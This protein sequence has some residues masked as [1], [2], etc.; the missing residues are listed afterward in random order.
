MMRPL[1]RGEVGV[2]FFPT[3]HR[4]ILLEGDFILVDRPF[5]PGD[6]CKRSLD[7]V[8]SGVVTAMEVKAILEHAI[9][10]SPV[11]GWIA[12]EDVE[13]RQEAEIGDYVAYDDWIGQVHVHESKV[14]DL[15]AYS[16]PSR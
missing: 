3:G 13:K 7:D 10:G 15:A 12:M 9:S 14:S 5:Q 1:K 16:L 11:E 4:E 2:S 8:R 6:L